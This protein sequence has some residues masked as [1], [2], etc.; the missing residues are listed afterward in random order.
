MSSGRAQM[1]R[2][3]GWIALL[4]T[5]CDGSVSGGVS[6]EDAGLPV[7]DAGVIAVTGES[8]FAAQC[9]AC[10]GPT[11]EGTSLAYQLR[12]PVRPYATFVIRNGRHEAI[13]F[14]GAMPSFSTTAVSDMNLGLIFDFLDAVPR[15]TDGQGL[16]V[17]FCGNCHG[18]E[19]EGG[20]ADEGLVHKAYDEPEEIE[21]AVRE[22]HGRQRYGDREEYM[23]AW[24]AAQLS[25]AEVT[26]IAAWL[27]TFPD[28][29]DD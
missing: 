3:I 19:G 4:L 8:L 25:D 2:W 22:G 9:A 26:L 10:H 6:E 13:T 14:T 28:P 1:R 12:S 17:R 23:P 11:G 5:A 29:G 24:T 7:V 21:E 15:P 16:Y 20:R 27:R 18:P